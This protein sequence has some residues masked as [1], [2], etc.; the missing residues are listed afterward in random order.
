MINAIFPGNRVKFGTN[1]NQSGKKKQF[2]CQGLANFAND[3]RYL[4]C[5][6]PNEIDFSPNDL[7][8]TTKMKYYYFIYSSFVKL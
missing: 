6:L 8:P 3:C 1:Q 4:V 7:Y 5:T 2:K